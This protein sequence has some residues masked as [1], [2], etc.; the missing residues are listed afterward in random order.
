[1][2]LK[3]EAYRMPDNF[4]RRAGISWLHRWTLDKGKEYVLPNEPMVPK[5]VLKLSGFESE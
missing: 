3:D 4:T 5:F 2:A 1:M